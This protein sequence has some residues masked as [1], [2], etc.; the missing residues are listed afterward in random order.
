MDSEGTDSYARSGGY[1]TRLFLMCTMFSS[2]FVYN[3]RGLLSARVFDDLSVVATILEGFRAG[4]GVFKLST[5]YHAQDWFCIP[6]WLWAVDYPRIQGVPGC[7][8]VCV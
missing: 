7:T 8:H 1:N 5:D 3:H 4:V 6:S 2:L